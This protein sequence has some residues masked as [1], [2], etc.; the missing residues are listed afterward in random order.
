MIQKEAEPPAKRAGETAGGERHGKRP[1]VHEV[2]DRVELELPAEGT[3]AIFTAHWQIFFPTVLIFLLYGAAVLVLWANGRSDTA[4]FR[5]FALVVG[6][7]VPLLAAHAFLRY[8]TVRIQLREGLLRYHPGWP[9][10][11]PTEIPQELIDRVF[12]K[13][14]LAGRLMGGGTVVIVTT[15]GN[16]IAIADLRDPEAVVRSF[17]AANDNAANSTINA[18]ETMGAS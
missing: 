16:R 11:T 12:V 2:E 10:D 4:L 8:S 5:L 14:G 17:N 13:R 7:G 3:N 6:V 18:V 15:A 1:T 9:K